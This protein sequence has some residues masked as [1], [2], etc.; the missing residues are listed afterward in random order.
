MSNE[1][2]ELI[3]EKWF[4]AFNDKD[5]EAI[6]ALYSED[7]AHYSPKLKL[8]QP[9][10]GGLVR[11]KAALRAWWLDS[12]E[13]LPTLEYFPNTFT[14]CTGRIFMEYTRKVAGE[15]DM[16]VAEVLE[17]SG[18]LIVASRVYHG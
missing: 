6:I 17:V 4:K 8:R 1:R 10:T 11:G 7:A 15:A 3:A 2:L 9:E 14:T 16:L 18:G 12:F 5:I 13:R